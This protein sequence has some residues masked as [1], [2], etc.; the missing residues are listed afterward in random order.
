M[1]GAKGT[2]HEEKR[3]D[4]DEDGDEDALPHDTEVAEGLQQQIGQLLRKAL[5]SM[6]DGASEEDEWDVLRAQREEITTL[7]CSVITSL[8][9]ASTRLKAQVA[10]QRL[11]P[12]SFRVPPAS[13]FLLLMV[14]LMCCLDSNS[15]R[16]FAPQVARSSPTAVRRSMR[17]LQDVHVKH[18]SPVVE[19]RVAGL[20]TKAFLSLSAIR[21]QDLAR[22]RERFLVWLLDGGASLSP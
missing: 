20:D 3:E 4:G 1:G 14:L 10:R 18:L 17:K 15:N 8:Q 5:I 16:T 7:A 9:Q 19:G 12:A 21:K 2:R 22:W 13:Y 6:L 11:L